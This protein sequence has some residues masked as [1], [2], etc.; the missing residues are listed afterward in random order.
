[1]T[2]VA[3]T[4]SASAVAAK[5]ASPGVLAGPRLEQFEAEITQAQGEG[6]PR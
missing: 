6:W 1:M 4:S 3:E 5:P 2:D